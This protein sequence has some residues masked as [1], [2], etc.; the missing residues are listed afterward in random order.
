VHGGQAHKS[1]RF[2]GAQ[3]KASKATG[4]LKKQGATF[5]PFAYVPLDGRAMS[6]KHG[7]KAVN[8]FASITAS[9]GK[10][11]HKRGEKSGGRGNATKT[12]QQSLGK[13]KRNSD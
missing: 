10:H 13:R 7:E 1:E 9:T 12:E 6:G 3:Y 2:S 8:R 11:G 5:E 4:D